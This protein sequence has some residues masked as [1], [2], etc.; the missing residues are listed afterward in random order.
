MPL[1]GMPAS[2]LEGSTDRRNR[3]AG[4]QQWPAGWRARPGWSGWSDPLIRRVTGMPLRIR[5]GASPSGPRRTKVLAVDAVV[6]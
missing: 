3:D 4:K 2:T 6:Q 1:V 5:K